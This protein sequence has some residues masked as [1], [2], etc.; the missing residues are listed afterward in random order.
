MCFSKNGDPSSASDAGVEARSSWFP[1]PCYALA[2]IRS[3]QQPLWPENPW[4][5]EFQSHTWNLWKVTYISLWHKEM[6]LCKVSAEQKFRLPQANL[7]KAVLENS[8]FYLEYLIFRLLEEQ[9]V[10]LGDLAVLSC[11]LQAGLQKSLPDYQNRVREKLNLRQKWTEV[12]SSSALI[13]TRAVSLTLTK[14]NSPTPSLSFTKSIFFL[15]Y[16]VVA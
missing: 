1:D 13:I 7:K 6:H 11:W 15:M 5:C 12:G 2:L 16:S 10:I 14:A 3:M 9:T 8:I 4:S